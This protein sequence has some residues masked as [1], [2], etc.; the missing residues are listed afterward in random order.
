MTG[1]S[2]K[3]DTKFRSDKVFDPRSQT[4]AVVVGILNKERSNRTGLYDNIYL[5]FPFCSEKDNP[6]EL[7]LQTSKLLDLG[8]WIS[9][10]NSDLITGKVNSNTWNRHGEW[11]LTLPYL[12]KVAM[13]C[14]IIV[15]KDF[16]V[17]KNARLHTK[18]YKPFVL[19]NKKIYFIQDIFD[20]ANLLHKNHLGRKICATIEYKC[21]KDDEDNIGHW[22]ITYIKSLG[23]KSYY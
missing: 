22:Y 12:G 9:I 11:F 5:V 15:H 13:E 20:E 16:W 23:Y 6:S 18:L 14:D 8:D 21:S 19:D 7:E 4:I 10:D 2:S 17:D 1:F 3:K